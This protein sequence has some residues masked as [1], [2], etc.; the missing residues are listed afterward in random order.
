MMPLTVIEPGWLYLL[1]NPAM[2]ALV[3]IGMTTRSPEERAQELAST[4]VP[5]PFHVAAAWAVDDVR[6]AERD[7]HAA[8]ARYRVNDARE[9]F[10]LSVPAA[11]KAL[12]RSTA[13]KPS[14]GRRAFRVLRGLVEAI[15]WFGIVMTLAA[16]SFGSG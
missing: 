2:P 6:A 7:A 3:K 4:G 8:L 10:R 1:T 15:G 11:I 13:S 16:L 5:M 9:W 14:L 12:G